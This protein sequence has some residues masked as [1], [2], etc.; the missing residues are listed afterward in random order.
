VES[1]G[2]GKTAELSGNLKCAGKVAE[3]SLASISYPSDPFHQPC[4]HSDDNAKARRG[5]GE[6]H[7]ECSSPAH[8]CTLADQIIPKRTKMR[9]GVGLQMKASCKHLSS[10]PAIPDPEARMNIPNSKGALS[11][12]LSVHATQQLFQICILCLSSVERS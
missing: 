1:I 2:H 8:S 9:E 10:N 5:S 11:L 7:D 12:Q 3:H 6:R 4:P